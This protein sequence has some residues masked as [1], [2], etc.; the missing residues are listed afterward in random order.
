MEVPVGR[1][2][3]ATFSIW[4]ICHSNK[5]RW[6]SS[7]ETRNQTKNTRVPIYVL[8]LSSLSGYQVGKLKPG[9]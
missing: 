6:T 3:K 8:S 1:I 9:M 4:R 7:K 2:E 5:R